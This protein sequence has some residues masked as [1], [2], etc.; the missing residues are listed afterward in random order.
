[1]DCGKF[2]IIVEDYVRELNG[3]DWRVEISEQF[4]N[5]LQILIGV[6]GWMCVYFFG[7]GLYSNQRN[8]VGFIL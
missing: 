8:Q 5:Y 6:G 7:M 1:M 3:L 2:M 4:L